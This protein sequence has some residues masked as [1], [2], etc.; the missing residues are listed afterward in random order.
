[1]SQGDEFD[2]NSPWA[3]S[4]K[5]IVS[6]MKELDKVKALVDKYPNNMELGKKVRQWYFEL[7]GDG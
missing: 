3:W 6:L 4:D 5:T 1:M 2:K 7:K